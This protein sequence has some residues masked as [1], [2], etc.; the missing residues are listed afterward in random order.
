MSDSF[1]LDTVILQ[2][3]QIVPLYC[4]SCRLD[5]LGARS[6]NVRFL[7]TSLSFRL[8]FYVVFYCLGCIVNFVLLYVVCMV[9]VGVENHLYFNQLIASLNLK[10]YKLHFLLNVRK[11]SYHIKVYDVGI[12]PKFIQRNT[13]SS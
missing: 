1:F 5:T 4:S 7:L 10:A 8:F 12:V 2:F 11:S 3:V 13:L 9:F 6:R